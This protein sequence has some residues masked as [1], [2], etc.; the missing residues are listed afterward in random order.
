MVVNCRTV[1]PVLLVVAAR[2]P[3]ADSTLRVSAP[4]MVSST[5]QRGLSPS[6]S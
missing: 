2:S 5:I 6:P 1:S 4:V 3:V